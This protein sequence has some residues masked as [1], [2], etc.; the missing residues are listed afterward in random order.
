[1][2]SQAKARRLLPR[3]GAATAAGGLPAGPPSM[4][5]ERAAAASIRS[6]SWPKAGAAV[7][8]ASIAPS[9]T[10]AVSQ[11]SVRT[12]SWTRLR[13]VVHWW[14]QTCISSPSSDDRPEHREGDL[15]VVGAP[16]QEARPTSA[17]PSTNE[18]PRTPRDGPRAGTARG[19]ERGRCS[20]APR[21][22]RTRRG[23]A[24]TGCAAA[25]RPAAA[26]R[27]TP[28]RGRGRRRRCTTGPARAAPSPPRT[29]WSCI[30]ARRSISACSPKRV[31]QPADVERDHPGDPEGVH[32]SCVVDFRE[33]RQRAIGERRAPRPSRRARQALPDGAAHLREQRMLLRAREVP[34]TLRPRPR[35]RRGTGRACST[36]GPG[37]AAAPGRP[38]ARSTI[39][40]WAARRLSRSRSTT[41]PTAP[42]RDRAVRR[43]PGRRPRRSAAR[44]HAGSPR[45]RRRPACSAA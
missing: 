28:D 23:P 30:R 5:L 14:C 32:A 24:S 33:P 12:N 34:G 42:R 13:S 11:S 29:G 7:L 37:R 43:R 41:R 36:A 45:P 16:Q 20:T 15:W 9:R 27:R 25:P 39:H 22:G 18:L 3:H 8:P 31:V 1:M 10:A 4:L 2:A 35:P 6:A 17:M 19:P 26:R 21:P 40:R 38:R 44:A